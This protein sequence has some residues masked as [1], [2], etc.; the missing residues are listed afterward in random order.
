MYI[1]NLRHK[2]GE[3]L[4]DKEWELLIEEIKTSITQKDLI[5]FIK[6][7]KGRITI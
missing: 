1:G 2:N 7:T 4:N 5:G 3:K 6:T